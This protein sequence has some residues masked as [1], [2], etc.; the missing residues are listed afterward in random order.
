MEKGFAVI[1]STIAL[2]WTALASA[3]TEGLARFKKYTMSLSLTHTHKN[4][5]CTKPTR[6]QS[7]KYCTS[8]L[9]QPKPEPGRLSLHTI[10]LI[11]LSLFRQV[12]LPGR[13]WEVHRYEEDVWG[14]KTIT[15]WLYWGDVTYRAPPARCE[16]SLSPAGR[17]FIAL[18]FTVAVISRKGQ[19]ENG[20]A[21]FSSGRVKQSSYLLNQVLIYV[22]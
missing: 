7:S 22:R 1:V 15:A 6:S 14:N 20:E 11:V 19:E 18:V 21:V 16:C 10:P 3:Q 13:G 17:C 4:T 9:S 2:Q 5:H 12:V 8:L